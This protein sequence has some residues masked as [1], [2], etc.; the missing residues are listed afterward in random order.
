M[1]Y[2]LE[3]YAYD[4]FGLKKKKKLNI[5]TILLFIVIILACAFLIY[6]VFSI[7]SNNLDTP[8][9]KKTAAIS[10]DEKIKLENSEV[11]ASNQ[12]VIITKKENKSSIFNKSENEEYVNYTGNH[13]QIPNH[14]IEGLKANLT[15]PQF[16]ENGF[17]LVRPIKV[18]RPLSI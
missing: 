14:D 12:E 11:V 16:N 2:G 4:E 6:I 8:D 7:I 3:D 9:I 18:I 1:L 5:K 17:E 15:I 10:E 13:M